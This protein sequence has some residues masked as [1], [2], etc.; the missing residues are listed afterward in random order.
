MLAPVLPLYRRALG[1]G[2]GEPA[3]LEADAVS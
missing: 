2:G 1:Q 3:P